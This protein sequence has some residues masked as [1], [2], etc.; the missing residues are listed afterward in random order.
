MRGAGFWLADNFTSNKATRAP[1]NDDT[2][3]TVVARM[4]ELGV[5]A[6][7]IGTSLLILAYFANRS[8][9]EHTVKVA[10]RAI[11]EVSAERAL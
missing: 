10:S 4:A 5:I 6:G 2:V 7:A 3:K 11:R 1:F 9:L 8:D